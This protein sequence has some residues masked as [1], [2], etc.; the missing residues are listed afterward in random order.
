[1][2]EDRT[3]EN[4]LQELLDSITEN[5]DKRKGS[6]IYDSLAPQSFLMAKFYQDLRWIIDNILFLDTASDEYLNK[7][8]FEFGVERDNAVAA[9]R[10]VTFV[11]TAIITNGT[12][13]FT[14][15]GLYWT[16]DNNY[17][18]CDTVGIVGNSTITGSTLIPV[19][20]I[21]G[22]E[23]AT[24][25]Q[26]VIP[27]KEIEDDESYRQRILLKIRQP[28]LNSNKAQIR[29][30]CNDVVGVGAAR[31]FPLWN[32]VNTVKAVLVDSEKKPASQI[33][34]D[35]VQQYIDPNSTGLGEGVADIGCVFTAKA[36]ETVDIN[37]SFRVTQLATGKDINDV[38]EET[39]AGL[40]SYL[41][42][43]AFKEESRKDI[44]RY[45]EIAAMLLNAEAIIDFDNLEVNGGTANIE[46]DLESVAVTGTITATQ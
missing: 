33:I 16:Y 9:V 29:K 21:Q 20:E 11:G 18:T 5:V 10:E 46:I 28:E 2:F 39:T 12:R 19:I 38:V 25:G 26:V 24:I 7:K 35:Q 43:L 34:V 8:G 31:V 45:Q 41:R 32:G 42:N 4:I 40:T 37:L 44:V 1:M 15:D 3:A 36:A 23:S 22:L 27:A 14:N 30:W 6:I 17:V 13:F